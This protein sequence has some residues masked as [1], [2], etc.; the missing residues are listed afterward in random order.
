M[1]VKPKDD[2][3]STSS[4][5]LSGCCQS[6][7]TT[8]ENSIAD[9]CI[10]D[11]EAPNNNTLF[12]KTGDDGNAIEVTHD[13]NVT[14]DVIAQRRASVD[15]KFPKRQKV[16]I[17]FQNIKYTV[18]QFSFKQRQF[19]KHALFYCFVSFKQKNAS[20]SIALDKLIVLII[21]VFFLHIYLNVLL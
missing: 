12:H 5:M 2:K 13:T 17:E 6:S 9:Y 11:A 20:K 19:G 8:P 4:A 1:S 21:I 16:D 15:F 3:P 7:N 18:K 10:E 14:V